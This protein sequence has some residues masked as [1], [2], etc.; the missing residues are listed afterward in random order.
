MKILI[1]GGAGFIGS[2][3]AQKLFAMGHELTIIDD[4]STGNLDNLSGVLN[5][6]GVR[7]FEDTIENAA[8]LDLCTGEAD[9][10]FHL[11]AAVGVKK[12]IEKPIDSMHRNINC[13]GVV[14]EAAGKHN[15]PVLI[16]STSEVY[17]KS[18]RHKF[19]ETDNLVFGETTIL[20]WSYACSKAIDE[21]LALAWQKHRGLPVIITRFFN[22]VGPGQSA[23][24][25]MVIP[26]FM[27]QAMAGEDL[28]IFGD[29]SQSRCFGHVYD[30]VN[31]LNMLLQNHEK[32]Y[33]EIFN[34]GALNEITIKEL[35]EQI[36]AL[37]G[38]S[39]K[40]AYI[41]YK[42][43]YNSQGTFEDIHRRMP[44]LSK[45]ERMVG[46]RPRQTMEDILQDVYDYLRNKDKDIPSAA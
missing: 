8:L 18:T 23:T 3:L 17:G 19:C 13:T 4:L 25:G 24:Y 38:S 39:S 7:F 21:Y 5:Q 15:T 32:L 27:Q 36:I 33:G 30:A 16:A 34:V 28:T 31:A 9:F 2:Y 10:V 12:I 35:A 37:T 40:I 29:G 11:A 22:C 1:T 44:D 14:L 45:I 43:V 42:D 41:D 26:R 6:D 46:Y 20:R